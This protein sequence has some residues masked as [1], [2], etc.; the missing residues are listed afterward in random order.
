MFPRLVVLSLENNHTHPSE[1]QMTILRGE[2]VLQGK[3]AKVQSHTGISS[4]VFF[5]EG[6]GGAVRWG[7]VQ[8]YSRKLFV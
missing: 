5:W 2:G 7:V 6:G 8:S 4:G 3:R 1:G